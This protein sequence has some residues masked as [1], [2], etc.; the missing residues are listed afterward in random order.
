MSEENAHQDLEIKDAQIIFEKVWDELI[1]ERDEDSLHFPSEIFWV[2][3]APGAGKGTHTATM[4][5][6][7]GFTAPPIIISD[8]LQS[9]EAQKRKE[10]GKLVGDT[11]VST[12]L[13]KR[14]LDPQFS[15]GAVV[16]GF[17]RTTVQV[18]FLKL[19]HA[20]LNE[21]STKSTTSSGYRKIRKPNFHILVL[22]VEEDESVRRQLH[23]GK[24]AIAHNKEADA[25]GIGEKVDVRST[26]LDAEKARNR[27]RVFKEQTYE[28]LKSLREIFHFHFIN[29]HASIEECRER[30]LRELEYQSSLELSQEVFDRLT[31][32]PIA[33]RIADHARQDLV[34]RLDTYERTDSVLFQRVIKLVSTKF[35]PIIERHAIS[36]RAYIN[37]EDSVFVNDKALAMLIDI[38]SE[39]GYHAAV[40]IRQEEIPYRIDPETYEITTRIKRVFQVDITFH[41]SEIRRGR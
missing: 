35:M 26:D 1:K 27:Y 39:R 15:S 11:E 24:E 31:G 21:I 13:L 22:F 37:T 33:T 34:E 29:T 23:R 10:A 41:G 18:Q 38:F 7:R 9:E 4:M 5:H 6:Y 8:L 19:F 20:K 12:L 14:L 17:P 36:G 30:I 32:I 3:G 16:D 25:S 40:N 28:P 2:N